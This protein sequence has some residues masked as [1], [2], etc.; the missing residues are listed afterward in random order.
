MAVHVRAPC[1]KFQQGTACQLFDYGNNIRQVAFDQG[2]E[3]AFDFPG[4]VPAY[5]RPLFC[6]GVGPF[7][8]VALSG[9]PE[10]I[11]RTDRKVKQLIPDGS[12]ICTAGWTRLVQRIQFQGLPAQ[13]L[14]GWAWDERDRL[15]LAFNEMVRKRRAEGTGGHR[16]GPPRQRLGG[17]SKPRDRIDARRIRRGF[18]LAAAKRA[19]QYRKRRHLG[20]SASRWRCW[21]GL[22]SACR[23]G[24]C[25]RWHA[26]R[27]TLRI[28]RVLWNDPA[29]GVM[30]H[31]DAGYQDCDR[32]RPCRH[33]LDL[34]MIAWYTLQAGDG[35][36]N[37]RHR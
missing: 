27:P 7:R 35:A 17:K 28:A 8:W 25:L 34:P 26:S 21:Y 36:M 15:G 37:D 19:A 5:V 13:H 31:A 16:Q 32:L 24:H 12:P 9:D 33:E 29:S 23:T 1:F 11:Y 3:D 30:R 14:L 4:F 22:R 20:V 18:R 10:D 6:R 2:V